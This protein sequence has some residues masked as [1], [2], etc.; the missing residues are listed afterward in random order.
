MLVRICIGGVVSSH[1]CTIESVAKLLSINLDYKNLH[2]QRKKILDKVFKPMSPRFINSQNHE[3]K[4]IC[5]V[6]L[7]QNLTANFDNNLDG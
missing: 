3:H 2:K 1:I 5:C 6:I 7:I 4:L